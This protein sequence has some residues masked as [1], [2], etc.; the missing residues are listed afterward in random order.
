M[1]HRSLNLISRKTYWFAI[2]LGVLH[3]L[4]APKCFAK[5]TEEPPR[6]IQRYTVSGY[7]RGQNGENLLGAT[8]QVEGAGL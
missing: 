8:V 4:H 2:L 3:L 7:L 6:K 5:D 1:S